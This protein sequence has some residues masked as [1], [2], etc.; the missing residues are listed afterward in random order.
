MQKIRS[1]SKRK[2]ILIIAA[3]I[4]IGGVAFYKIKKG[5]F[6]SKGL[7]SLVDDKSNSL[8]KITYDSITI[9]EIAGNVFIKNLRLKGDTLWQLNMISQGDTNAVKLLL[10]I[11]IPTLQ[12]K[13]FKTAKALLNNQ[14]ECGQIL[15]TNPQVIIYVFASQNKPVNFRKQQEQLYKQILGNFKKIKADSV[16]IINAA[17]TTIDFYTKEVKFQTYNTTI[18]LRD[19]AI[20]NISNQDT[21]RTLFC[22]EI[23]LQTRKVYLGTQS[24]NGEITDLSFNTHSQLLS[25]GRIDYDAF[26]NG[27]SFKSFAEGIAING[28]NWE[29]P[30]EHSSLTI[31]SAIISKGE[32]EIEPADKPAKTHKTVYDPHLLTGWIKQFSINKLAAKSVTIIQQP[33]EGN[34]Q[35]MIVKGNSFNIKNVLI[36]STAKLQAKLVN[37][38]KEVE[39]NNETISIK[40]EDGLYEYRA[41]GIRINTAKRM[42]QIKSFKIIPEYGEEAFAHKAGKQTD[43]YDMAFNNFV[44]NNLDIEK[45]LEGKL[46]AGLVT[47]GSNTVK[48]YHD[49]TYPIDSLQRDSSY[50]TYPQEL[51]HKLSVPVKID[52]MI[53]GSTYIEYK[54]KEVISQKTG[55]VAL[56]KSKLDITNISNLPHKPGDKMI[57]RFS[58]MFLNQITASGNFTFYLD[59]WR[60][61]KFSISLNTSKGGDATLISPLTEPMGM[62]KIEKGVVGPLS[63]SM[64][65][66]T[67]SSHSTLSL[68]YEN[69][70]VSLLKMK[71]EQ[72]KKK[73]VLSLLANLIVKNNNR[74]GDKFRTSDAN[75]H[76]NP[77]KSF[78]NFIWLNVYEGIKQVTVLK[79]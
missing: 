39:V 65:A 43:R 53:V 41:G 51:L 37:Y 11:D 72:Y 71:D 40:T 27:G 68:P 36:D 6:L 48:V 12:V 26:K 46:I 30:V 70:K 3:I 64:T 25:L 49:L 47:T 42:L 8:Y 34:K 18:G 74:V 32:I 55:T 67:A 5:N 20:D 77:Y 24:K 22:K 79:I 17:V 4:I 15:I 1:T 19:V 50:S 23:N 16:A 38:A 69:M 9:N 59:N 45:L 13:H 54:E 29:G 21:T 2:Y 78:F 63:F 57:A 33:K 35:P 61:G 28:I 62:A 14:M 60:A 52:R 31:N 66:D 76:R 58:S 75:P 7:P 44:F 73:G 56:Y 10:D